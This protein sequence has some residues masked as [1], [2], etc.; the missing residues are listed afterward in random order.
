[1]GYN[2]ISVVSTTASSYDLTTLEMVKSEL[3][4][5]D[6]DAET[7]D[8]SAAE[9]ARRARRDAWLKS[10]ITQCS[11]AIS[12]YC[13]RVFAVETL[14]DICLIEQDAYPY[15]VPGG[16][17]ALQLSRFP[18]CSV[19]SVVQ[20][21]SATQ[22]VSLSAAASDFLLDDS[23]GQLIRLAPFTGVPVPWEALTT[24]VIYSAGYATVPADLEMACLRLVTQRYLEENL[25][26]RLKR[27]DQPNTGSKEYWIGTTPGQHGTLPPEIVSLLDGQYR[28]PVVA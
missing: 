21:A 7:V 8:T 25:D 19:V 15:Q 12:N 14:T 3:N 17:R 27:I 5:D 16:V 28:V 22:T 4:I 11:M 1:M 18:V 23:K 24:T 26:P 2:V 10:A 9:D 20:A 6:A 13:N